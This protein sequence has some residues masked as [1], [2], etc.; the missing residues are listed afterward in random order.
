VSDQQASSSN[1]VQASGR[2]AENIVSG[3]AN[4]PTL[5]FIILLN[6]TMIVAAAY[7]L[8]EQ[9]RNRINTAN[10]ITDLLR[11]CISKEEGP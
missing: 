4:T 5:L 9:E 11:L 7:Y 10:Q 3:L 6:V 2:V 1:I 8:A